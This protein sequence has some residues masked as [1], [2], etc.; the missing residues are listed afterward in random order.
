MNHTTKRTPTALVIPPGKSMNS[1]LRPN[2]EP[3]LASLVVDLERAQQE[4]VDYVTALRIHGVRVIELNGQDEEFSRW[5]DTAAAAD[6]VFPEDTM[7]AVQGRGQSE[8]FFV[9][10]HM[11]AKTRIGEHA[12][13]AETVKRLGIVSEEKCLYVLENDDEARFEAGDI[14]QACRGE[15][16]L[17]GLSARSNHAGFLRWQELA[18]KYDWG[19]VYPVEVYDCG[20]HLTTASGL[21]DPETLLFDPTLLSEVCL[22]AISEIDLV[23][24]AEEDRGKLNCANCLYLPGKKVVAMDARFPATMKKVEELGYHVIAL[25][26][27]QHAIGAGG[28]TCRSLRWNWDA[29]A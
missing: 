8:P 23:E 10:A 7:R 18:A 19:K 26:N 6:S 28:L 21:L 20:L 3:E 16:I 11:S 2:V 13:V 25:P 24:V 9:Q 12:M 29:A 27:L 17:Y 4:Y 14:I 22:R 5:R 15:S 1:F